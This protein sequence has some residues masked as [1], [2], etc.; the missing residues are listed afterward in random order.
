M[1]TSD[2]SMNNHIIIEEKDQ[3]RGRIIPNRAQDTCKA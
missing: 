2:G 3:A 1:Q